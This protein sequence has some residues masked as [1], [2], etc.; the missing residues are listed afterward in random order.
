ALDFPYGDDR[1][2]TEFV[3]DYNNPQKHTTKLQKMGQHLFI[4]RAVDDL[5]YSLTVKSGKGIV[6]ERAD[7]VKNPHKLV[8]APQSDLSQYTF[9]F[10]KDAGVDNSAPGDIFGASKG[11]WKAYWMSGAAVDFSECTDARAF[12]LERRIVT[13]QYLMKVNNAGSLPPAETGLFKNSWYGK[14]HF[15]MIW[16]HGVHFSLWKRWKELDKMLEVYQN[17][18][19]TSIE[20]A[21]G[22]G[23]PGARWPKA[24]ANIDREWPFIIHAFLIW[25]QPHPIYFA[26]LDYRLHPSK[27]TLEKWKDVVFATADFMAAYPVYDSAA[28]Q[29]NIEAPV[30]LVSEN[31]NHDSTRNPAFELSYWRYGLRTA[32]EWRK[33]LQLPEAPAWNTVLKNLAPL[34]VE[35]NRYVTFEGITD[36]WTKYNFEHPGLIATY[37]ML[38]G[39]G[40][41]TTILRNT[42]NEVLKTWDFDR[43]WGWDFPVVAMCAA[44]LQRP[45]LAI[46]ML[47]YQ[48][49]HN[50]YDIPGYNSWVYFPANGGLLTA[51]AM[52]AGGWDGG[53]GTY[54]P[55]F[56]K[57]GKWKVRVEG[58]GKMQ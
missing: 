11:G 7:S 47:L 22:Q 3:G 23:Y 2:F 33:R 9:H 4:Q 30:F 27:A 49:K 20:R 34:P 41:D 24:T 1:E 45:E 35:N 18:L 51:I 15:E 58:F 19:P 39:D 6:Y 5:R 36:M 26:E 53:P 57:N 31:T 38:P 10:S 28:K 43:T 21:K 14:F 44:K 54:A 12:E 37:G 8:L 48:N 50:S 13:S 25:Q 17:F 16:W 46:D 40:V 29:Y 56:P 42:F 52:M 55:G 32:I